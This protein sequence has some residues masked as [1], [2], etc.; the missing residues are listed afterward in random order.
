MK[1][2]NQWWRW[3][4]GVVVCGCVFAESVSAAQ[5]AAAAVT[6]SNDYVEVAI[7]GTSGTITVVDRVAKRTWK[8][9]PWDNSA[10][11]LQVSTPRESRWY[12]LSRNSDV[13]ATRTSQHSARIVYRGKGSSTNESPWS[14]TVEVSIR[15][16]A[17]KLSLRVIAVD[18]PEGHVARRLYYP[19]RP[20][21][22]RTDVDHGAAVIP[23]WQGVIVPS[24]IFPMNGGSFCMWD[25][26]QHR[27]FAIGELWYYCTS[28]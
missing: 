6:L 14:V 16:D 25:D 21:S 20:F 8:P 3:F 12:D 4:C 10:G 11:L 1:T 13:D 15:P 17:G 28:C 9:D 22:L 18:V 2:G 19:A 27:S 23:F 5:A 26:A 24:Y 7:D